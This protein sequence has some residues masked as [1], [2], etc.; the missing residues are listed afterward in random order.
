[1]EQTPNQENQES[2]LDSSKR[3]AVCPIT[4]GTCDKK[5]GFPAHIRIN[6]APQVILPDDPAEA[7]KC[8]GCE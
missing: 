5:C 4:D 7:N 2:N 1:M 8:D 6:R 3:V